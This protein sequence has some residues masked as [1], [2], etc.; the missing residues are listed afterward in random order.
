LDEAGAADILVSEPRVEE[1]EGK[2]HDVERTAKLAESFAARSLQ[3]IEL[4]TESTQLLQAHALQ[5]IANNN[6][7]AG[8]GAGGSGGGGSRRSGKR[9]K[10]DKLVDPMLLAKELE[11]MPDIAGT[12]HY[13]DLS[14]WTHISTLNHAL[15]AKVDTIS[16]DVRSALAGSS[17][18]G[19]GGGGGAGAGSSSVVDGAWGQGGGA[20]EED[21]ESFRDAFMGQL[22]EDFSD[23]LDKLRHVRAAPTCCCSAVGGIRCCV[24]PSPSDVLASHCLLLGQFH[25]PVHVVLV[26]GAGREALAAFHCVASSPSPFLPLPA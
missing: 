21:R 13:Q 14:L 8:A 20:E 5:S 10:Q 1:G 12:E 18:G 22:T 26:L 4:M 7:G 17:G 6:S 2:D 23:D 16:E 25:A 19:G 11:A 9:S 24:V 3:L 15:F